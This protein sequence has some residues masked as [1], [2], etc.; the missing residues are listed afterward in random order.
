MGIEKV[1]PK[2]ALKTYRYLRVGMLGS[3]LLLAAAIA[4]EAYEA[5]GCWQESISAYYYTPVRGIFVGVLMAIG[6]ALIVIKGPPL[7]DISLNIAGMFAPVVAI[8]P[9]TAASDCSSVARRADPV[10]GSG[11]DRELAASVVESAQNNFLALTFVGFV[12]LAVACCLALRNQRANR[13]TDTIDKN[14]RISAVITVTLLV[15]SL[16]L[17]VTWDDFVNRAHGVAAAVMFGALNV[18][19]IAKARA[20]KGSSAKYY[21][22]YGALAW[23]MPV[24]GC[25][26]WLLAHFV[27][28]THD[29]LIVELVEIVFFVIFWIVQTADNWD[30]EQTSTPAIRSSMG[31]STG[32]TQE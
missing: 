29:I 14:M 2:D 7:Q 1:D 25:A 4:I 6:L 15:G 5:S 10:L 11:A 3:V 32:L 12:G 17:A 28:S 26:A 23:L 31:A 22:W 27:G 30:I 13:G 9:T 16:V 21:G 19:V 8:I 20:H 24:G 18:A